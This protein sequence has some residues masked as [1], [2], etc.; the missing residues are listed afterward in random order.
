MRAIVSFTCISKRYCAL[1]IITK[2]NDFKIKNLQFLFYSPKRCIFYNLQ[3][4]NRYDCP[5]FLWK[6][7]NLRWNLFSKRVLSYYF[8]LLNKILDKNQSGL[9]RLELRSCEIL[10]DEQSYPLKL[11]HLQG[12]FN[13]TSRSQS[14]PK[15]ST[16]KKDYAVI[17]RVF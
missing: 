2:Y 16:Y 13:P 3:N 14:F 10:K 15:M 6:S 4:C 9:R 17:P 8:L 11:L 1:N 12:I 7:N 5:K